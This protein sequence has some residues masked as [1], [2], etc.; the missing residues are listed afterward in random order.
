M[1]RTIVAALCLGAASQ[2]LSQEPEDAVVVTASRF[3]E[4]RLEAPVAMTVITRE[5]IARDT[6]QTLPDLLSRL[7]GMQTR[8][9]SSPD[10]QIDL[11]GFG[12]TGDQNTLVLLD[13]V[14]I[15]ENDLSSTKLSTIPLQSIE[16]I[17]ILRGSGSVLYGDN[18]PGGTINIITRSPKPERSGSVFAGAGTYNTY[19]LRASANLPG[20]QL[21]SGA[22]LSAGHQESDNYRVN[23]RL[24][25]DNFAGDL[26]YAASANNFGLKFGADTQRLQLP[27]TRTEEQLISDPR[28]TDTPGNWSSRESAFTTFSYGR[29]FAGADLAADLGYREKL[30]TSYFAGGSTPYGRIST[31][32]WA[33]SPRLRAPFQLAGIDNVLVVGF[34]WANWDYD[35]RSG[36]SL[37]G[38]GEPNTSPSANFGTLGT[39]ES[40][41]VYLQYN[42]QLASRTKL[43]LGWRQQ[44]VTDTRT[45]FGFEQSQVQKPQAED[46][47]LS[48]G[49]GERWQVYGRVGTNFR[50]ANVDENGLTATGNLLKAQTGRNKEAGI[51][52]RAQNSTARLSVYRMDLDNEIYFSPLFPN[53]LGFNGAN[54]NLS[55]TLRRGVELF[56]SQ[57]VSPQLEFSGNVIVQ[58]ATF[59]DGVYGGVNVTGNEIPL[60][61][62]TLANLRASWEFVQN[63]QLSGAVRYVGKQRYDADQANLFHKMPTYTV[64][65]LKLS[66]RYRNVVAALNINNLFDKAYYSYAIVKPATAPTT[67][68]AYPE[69]RR[70]VMATIELAL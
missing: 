55:P 28:G 32:S 33:F 52:Y 37:D 43:T 13:G 39:Q 8:Y 9:T 53:P 64:A 44:R 26:R 11:R 57:R 1:K 16:R 47:A 30:S 3:P 49:F 4:K 14:R 36:A 17:E 38:F 60:V 7:G 69:W 54:L 35:S 10:K 59:K 58:R 48:Q 19:D 51:E 2:A 18:A 46:V 6:A 66:H 61:P 65:D 34:D 21:G 50:I 5:E 63:T 12:I 15:N 24:R 45:S 40:S 23:N 67:F 29:S 25:Q 68:D 70:S 27:G 41:G 31:R 20:E 22:T 56:A 62:E 42:G